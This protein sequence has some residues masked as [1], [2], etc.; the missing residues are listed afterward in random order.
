MVSIYNQLSRGDGFVSKKIFPGP[1]YKDFTGYEIVRLTTGEKRALAYMSGSL[2][3]Q[4]DEIYCCGP[5]H[6]SKAAFEFAESIFVDIF[7][8][9][10]EPM[11]IDE[12]GPL[13]LTGRGFASILERALK[14]RRDLYISVRNQCVDEVI[15]EFNIRDYK[16]IK[17]GQED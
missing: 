1:G 15:K 12:I 2:P 16:L 7:A 6:F 9:G 14:T 5:Y 4:W 3:A 10:I 17:V 8:R 11:F 13:E